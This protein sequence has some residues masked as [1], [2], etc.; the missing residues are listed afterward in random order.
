MN[1]FEAPRFNNHKKPSDLKGSPDT[2]REQVPAISETTE[3]TVDASI[4]KAATIAKKIDSSSLSVERKEKL[5][6]KLARGLRKLVSIASFAGAISATINYT[7]T[8]HTVESKVGDTGEISY[9]HEDAET[10]HLINV[11]AGKD[12]LTHAELE[13]LKIQGTSP[14][15]GSYDEELYKALWALEQ[16]SGNPK[17]RF[18]VNQRKEHPI[19]FLLSKNRSNYDPVTNTVYINIFSSDEEVLHQYIAELSHGIQFDQ[20]PITSTTKSISDIVPLIGKAL[21]Q[22]SD[23]TNTSLIGRFV[24]NYSST[25]EMPGTLEH[26]AHSIIEPTL[27]NKLRDLTPKRTHLR[28]R[29]EL[30]AAQIRLALEQAQKARENIIKKYEAIQLKISDDAEK[31]VVKNPES[32]DIIYSKAR[33]LSDDK[34]RMQEEEIKA[35]SEYF[36]KLFDRKDSQ[37]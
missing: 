21:L 24:N 27:E 9:I 19:K 6:Y 1:N 14:K 20:H 34:S 8:R 12:T 18:F 7:A 23:A 3:K 26:D 30:Q 10:T 22:K 16:E 33:A 28:T 31:L 17:V 25:Y 35:S 29:E 11:L 15:M 36:E 4:E 37:N 32:K 2:S 13:E 5:R